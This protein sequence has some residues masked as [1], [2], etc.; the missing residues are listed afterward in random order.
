MREFNSSADIHGRVWS[1]LSLG[2]NHYWDSQWPRYDASGGVFFSYPSELCPLCHSQVSTSARALIGTSWDGTSLGEGRHPGHRMCAFLDTA[3]LASIFVVTAPGEELYS[4]F[5]EAQMET[6]GVRTEQAP[7]RC[8]N[9]AHNE[10]LTH[11]GVPPPG[12]RHHIYVH[13]GFILE[14]SPKEGSERE[15]SLDFTD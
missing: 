11:L 5:P 12:H 6:E 3:S 9:W 4:L 15:A 8:A 2:S 10:F 1:L 7:L 14:T 13:M